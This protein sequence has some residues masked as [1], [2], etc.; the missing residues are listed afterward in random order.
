MA[1]DKNGNGKPDADEWYEIQ[2]SA[3]QKGYREPWYVEAECAGN[4]VNCYADY[5]ITYYKPQSEPST[6][7]E[8]ENTFAGQTI[9][10]VKGIFLKMSTTVSRTSRNGFNQIN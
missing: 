10:E 1:Y 7:E 3:Q 6:P 9:K 8:D 5:E 2:G 4:D